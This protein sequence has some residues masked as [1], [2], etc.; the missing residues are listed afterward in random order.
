MT[1]LL[2]NKVRNLCTMDAFCG[3]IVQ[4]PPSLGSVE[5]EVRSRSFLT[6]CRTLWFISKLVGKISIH[7]AG[8]LVQSL[9]Y[10]TPFE[11]RF[12]IHQNPGLTIIY[13]SRVPVKSPEAKRK[14]IAKAKELLPEPIHNILNRNYQG[15]DPILFTSI[16]MMKC[17]V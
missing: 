12:V 7:M 8:F 5:V 3:Y 14:D 16:C 9:G 10:A 17:Q 13:L 15:D 1:G 2:N 4:F 11:L 6:T